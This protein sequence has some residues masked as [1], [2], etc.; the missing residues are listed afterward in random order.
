MIPVVRKIEVCG[1]QHKDTLD[2]LKPQSRIRP[3]AKSRNN[4]KRTKR[5]WLHGS[6]R[7]RVCIFGRN[8][9]RSKSHPKS[10]AL[11]WIES[12]TFAVHLRSPPT[13]A[14]HLRSSPPS[15]ST[16][17]HYDVFIRNWQD[18]PAIISH[19]GII[20]TSAKVSNHARIRHSSP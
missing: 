12:P 18:S 4:V 9:R 15:P 10:A 13:F 7:G 20:T 1:E 16:N 19:A 5:K 17:P 11:F 8:E 6:T 2:R 3:R 14:L